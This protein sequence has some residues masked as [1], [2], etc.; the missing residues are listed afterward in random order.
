MRRV[1]A[2]GLFLVAAAAAGSCSRED[3]YE[4]R[5]RDV[6]QRVQ[7]PTVAPGQSARLATPPPAAAPATIGE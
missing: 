4:R 7:L 5:E 1:A 2:I 3:D 6:I